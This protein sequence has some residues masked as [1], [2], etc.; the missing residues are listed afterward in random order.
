MQDEYYIET[1]TDVLSFSHFNSL[2]EQGRE[3]TADL[4]RVQDQYYIE[5]RTDDLFYFSFQFSLGTG[6]DKILWL[7]TKGSVSYSK[8]QV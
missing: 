4:Q 3:W 1:M 8:I 2:W 5:I 7:D 6:C